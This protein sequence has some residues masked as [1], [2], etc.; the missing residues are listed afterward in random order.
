[1]T[2]G[3]AIAQI[4][5]CPGNGFGGNSEVTISSISPQ[6][7]YPDSAGEAPVAIYV[8]AFQTT[9]VG[10]LEPYYD[11]E[12]SWDFG[13]NS[14]TG[15]GTIAH[16][17]DGMVQSANTDQR[18]P[19]ACYLYETP[20]TYQITLTVRG[21]DGSNYISTS[22]SKS[23]T[24][25]A[26]SG[27][28]RYVD[29]ISGDDLNDGLS[30]A[31]PWQTW[32]QAISWINGG[33]NRRVLFKRGTTVDVSATL[34][35]KKSGIRMGAYGVG[36][37]PVLMTNSGLSASRTIFLNGTNQNVTDHVYQDLVFDG[38]NVSGA[39]FFA[40]ADPSG[41]V[42]RMV[43]ADCTLQNG[44]NEGLIITTGSGTKQAFLVWECDFHANQTAKQSFVPADNPYVAVIGG[45]FD[46]GNGNALLDH[47]MYINHCDHTVIRWVT[48]GQSVNRNFCL[49]MNAPSYQEDFEY[50]L[51]D[52]CDI[53]GTNNGI[54]FS[55][56]NNDNTG[57]FRKAIVQNCQIHDLTTG[58]QGF[59]V[60]G[61]SVKDVAIRDNHFFNNP[62]ND[63]Y[64]LDT[65]VQYRV[66]RNKFYTP[67]TMPHDAV[68]VISGQQGYFY[69]NLFYTDATSNTT[70]MYGD[71]S[72]NYQ[73]DYNTY[74][75]PSIALPFQPTNPW[76]SMNFAS[77]QGLGFDLNGSQI[78]PAFPDPGNGDFG[79]SPTSDFTYVTNGLQVS[80]TDQ[81]SGNPM[82]WPL[83]YAWDF[84]DAS[85]LNTSS[86]PVY[87]YAAAGQ[88]DVMLTVSN[89]CG[90]H[91]ST[92]ILNLQSA[93]CLGDFNNDNSVDTVDLLSFLGGIGCVDFCAFDLD[94]DGIAN[95]SDLLIFLG[96]FGTQC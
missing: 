9:A 37:D 82:G 47:H 75:S 94:N 68:S 71:F 90:S 52:G 6:I 7:H 26:W 28:D 43:F 63:I 83:T 64:I 72:V 13:D 39:L 86:S 50:C 61:Y 80:F 81:S 30:V 60:F 79:Q 32:T 3:V 74:W 38:N 89:S 85:A 66:Y 2:F 36:S 67:A 22:T 14:P 41:S 1:M 65:D 56:G 17:V 11:L 69:H 73:I 51:I 44:N 15:Q 48:F 45:H 5:S 20:G 25:S 77:W 53:T 58:N 4:P 21:W 27:Q 54:D 40:Y 35:T 70:H 12:Y 93:G 55:N 33:N 23:V 88:F 87:D 57:H 84:G 96:L 31:T 8:S 24:I 95:T 59:G 34:T 91:A 19:E 46:G 78:N 76:Q 62:I 29:P 16:P 49:N 42:E 92:Q 18:G 10:T